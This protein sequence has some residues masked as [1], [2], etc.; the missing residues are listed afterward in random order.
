[1]YTLQTD[2]NSL[3]ILFY[4]FPDKPTTLDK[5]FLKSSMT[6]NILKSF[7]VIFTNI[8]KMTFIITDVRAA[9]DGSRTAGAEHEPGDETQ[10]APAAQPQPEVHQDG[11]A[12][13]QADERP[14]A[15]QRHPGQPAAD[16]AGEAGRVDA[17]S[18]QEP[19]SE[20]RSE[21]G[22]EEE[23]E[24]QQ[25]HREGSVLNIDCYFTRLN[26]KYQF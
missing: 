11:A 23:D 2:L 4:I 19:G 18:R 25:A 7:S 15:E 13:L 9:R 20:R 12:G 17:G 5:C 16:E 22:G 24:R 14:G 8:G 1:M 21:P 3:A 10:R 6:K 26:L